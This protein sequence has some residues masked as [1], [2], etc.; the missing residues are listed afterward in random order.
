MK[1]KSKQTNVYMLNG[2]EQTSCFFC[3]DTGYW[4]II[5]AAYWLYLFRI[6]IR[7]SNKIGLLTRP[8]WSN[9]SFVSLLTVHNEVDEDG[10]GEESSNEEN[11]LVD[12]LLPENNQVDKAN[13]FNLLI[14]LELVDDLCV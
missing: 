6:L 2:V 14:V 8:S 3:E 7:R 10:E 12:G 1:I 11:I 4:N 5:M 9:V 13:T